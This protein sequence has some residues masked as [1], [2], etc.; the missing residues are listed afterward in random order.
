MTV[1]LP[2]AST[3]PATSYSLPAWPGGEVARDQ[4]RRQRRAAGSVA[5]TQHRPVGPMRGD[6]PSA[7]GLGHLAL[8]VEEPRRVDGEAQ[9]TVYLKTTSRASGQAHVK[10]AFCYSGSTARRWRRRRSVS[11]G[12]VT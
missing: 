1:R 8:R 4:V 9:Q 2:C 12:I 11:G 5:T 3:M 10:P 7:D 6:R